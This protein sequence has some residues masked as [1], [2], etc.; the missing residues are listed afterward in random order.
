MPFVLIARETA[1]AKAMEHER[2]TENATVIQAMQEKIAKLAELGSMN[3]S[4]TKV[5]CFARNVMSH[6]WAAVLDLARRTVTSARTAGS[7][8]TKKAA[9]TSTNALRK[10]RVL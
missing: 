4:R 5:N 7:K 1:H 2:G 3:P 10:I 9:T 6:V 8:K